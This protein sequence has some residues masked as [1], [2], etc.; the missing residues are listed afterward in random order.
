MVPRPWI[1]PKMID[2]PRSFEVFFRQHHNRICP[3]CQT[4]PREVLICLL[5]GTLVCHSANCCM[6]NGLTEI[7]SHRNECGVG[8]A[9]YLSVQTS[10]VSVVRGRRVCEWGSLYLDAHGEEDRELKRG[11]PLFL[12][13]ERYA[14]LQRQW[15]SHRFDLDCRNWYWLVFNGQ[16]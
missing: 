3:T 7:E 13:E 12:S 11:R 6:A 14:F 4:S 10:V 5:C 1:L 15:L 9:V 8:T 16:R 2:L